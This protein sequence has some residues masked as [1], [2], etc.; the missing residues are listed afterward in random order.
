M[1]IEANQH[2]FTAE[3]DAPSFS[4]IEDG[5]TELAKTTRKPSLSANT[6][7]AS[8]TPKLPLSSPPPRSRNHR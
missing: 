7:E 6:D 4:E 1:S 2:T 8:E 5:A 3:P